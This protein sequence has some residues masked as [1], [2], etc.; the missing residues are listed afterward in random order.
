M[1]AGLASAEE[2][3][4]CAQ[5]APPRTGAARRATGR[6]RL[7]LCLSGTTVRD[8]PA[9]STL[10]STYVRST[11]GRFGHSESPGRARLQPLAPLATVMRALAAHVTSTSA[12]YPGHAQ[13]R[14]RALARPPTCTVRN[15]YRLAAQRRV[16]GVLAGRM[17]SGGGVVATEG[18]Q[19]HPRHRPVAPSATPHLLRHEAPTSVAP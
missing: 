10:C 19:V 18:C 9:C 8:T 14:L 7:A 5:R 1:W 16:R 15:R 17:C 3:P 11:F 6:W 13:E 2:L 12:A 4:S